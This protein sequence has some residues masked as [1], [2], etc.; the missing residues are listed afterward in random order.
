MAIKINGAPLVPAPLPASE[1]RDVPG[2]EGLYVV[3]RA[4]VVRR[5]GRAKPCSSCAKLTEADVRAIRESVGAGYAALRA[6]YGI[7]NCALHAVIHRLTAAVSA[8]PT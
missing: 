1:W 7:G 4:D 5:V 6:E 2:Y 8:S 3:N